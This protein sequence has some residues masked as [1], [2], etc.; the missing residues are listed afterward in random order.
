MRKQILTIL[1]LLLSTF[2][3]AQSQFENAEVTRPQRK[4]VA[5]SFTLNSADNQISSLRKEVVTPY[6]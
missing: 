4:V 1:A 2:S 5:V 6:I 3:F